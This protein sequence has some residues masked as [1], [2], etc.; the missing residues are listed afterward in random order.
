MISF[1]LKA[2]HWQIFLL[3]F[4]ILFILEI[5]FMA[6][7]FSQIMSHH[8]MNPEI[9]LYFIFIA[10]P[11]FSL[12]TISTLFAW[13]WSVVIGLQSKIPS[14]F[15]MPITRI[16][17]FII[18]PFTYIFIIMMLVI[19]LMNILMSSPNANADIDHWIL[20]SMFII[21]PMHLISM[22]SMLHTLYYVAKTIKTVELQRKVSF[23]DFAGE[24][25]LVWFFPIGIWI[26]Q[27]R[28]NRW[29]AEIET[30]KTEE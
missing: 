10:M 15:Q 26:L 27:P 25:F 22:A 21:I 23:S 8:E 14:E 19:F 17:I 4:G 16:K 24:F 3:S 13:F 18:L 12:V 29:A 20:K 9:P 7:M 30:I 11:L 5:F 28:I 1:I 6:F 2:K